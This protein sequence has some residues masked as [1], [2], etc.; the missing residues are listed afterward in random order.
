[1][2]VVEKYGLIILFGLCALIVGVGIFAE[3]PL[4]KEALEQKQEAATSQ[5]E[6]LQPANNE[7]ITFNDSDWAPDA[8][9]GPVGDGLMS[10]TPPTDS[11]LR[12]PDPRRESSLGVLPKNIDDISEPGES[13][14]GSSNRIT[15]RDEPK[16]SPKT[17]DYVVRKGDS[18][19]KIATNQLGSTSYV[20]A[21][22]RANPQIKEDK[23]FTGKTIQIPI[24]P[25]TKKT[26]SLG[27]ARYIKVKKGET[28]SAIAKREYGDESKWK[29]LARRNGIKRDR[30]LKDSQ[31]L[32]IPA[33]L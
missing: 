5:V 21:I 8:P 27:K 19:G 6:G 2:P 15:P 3:D 31:R 24:M 10:Y 33:D 20:N 1:M 28:L 11:D 18:L 7:S 23:V 26:S 22:R 25:G 4:T 29:A 32:L 14:K 30:D 12:D 9:E 17:Y 13:R 16:T